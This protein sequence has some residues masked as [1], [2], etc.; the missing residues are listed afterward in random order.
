VRLY[1]PDNG[2]KV[3]EALKV[4]LIAALTAY[5]FY[6]SAW[7][8]A[9]GIAVGMYIVRRDYEAYQQRSAERFMEGFR[10]MLQLVDSSISA[11]SSLENAFI[12]AGNECMRRGEAYRLM[13]GEFVY[14]K[15]G[16]AC[17]RKVEELLADVGKRRG[18]SEIMELAGLI[19][20]AKY[21]GGD[22][23]GLIRQFNQNVSR[24]KMLEQEL[25]TMIAA[26]RFEGTIM[27]LMPYLMILYMRLTT[28]GYTDALYETLLGRFAMTG[29]LV[30][31]VAAMVLMN[32]IVDVS[33]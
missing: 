11:G 20:I 19:S 16:L 1:K 27:V 17:N 33:I 28:P 23:S 18:A 12:E 21:Y 22:I 3:V 2:W 15:N 9:A 26:K 29:A 25:D 14:M 24:R 31:T 32:R 8:M 5:C 7:G 13:Q 6:N 4:L 10:D 30:V